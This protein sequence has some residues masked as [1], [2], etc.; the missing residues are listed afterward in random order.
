MIRG[1]GIDIVDVADM[2]RRLERGAI[3][4]VFSEAELAYADARPG[5]RAQIL[6][7]RWAAKEAFGKA[8][9]TGLRLGWP[10]AEIEVTHDLERRPVLRLGPAVAHLVSLGGRIHLSLSHTPSCA[11]AVVIIEEA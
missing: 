6:A 1:I 9:G 2:A 10:H 7:A 4:K 11:V 5:R 3:K 8:L